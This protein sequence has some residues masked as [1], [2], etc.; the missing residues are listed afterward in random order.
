MKF[1]KTA[2][3]DCLYFFTVITW[4]LKM[5]HH[6]KFPRQIGDFGS[7]SWSREMIPLWVWKSHHFPSREKLYFSPV[8]FWQTVQNRK[9]KQTC[10]YLKVTWVTRLNSFQIAQQ[11]IISLLYVYLKVIFLK[12]TSASGSCHKLG[13]LILRVTFFCNFWATF[14]VISHI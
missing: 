7:M 13:T 3:L 1:G 2:Q 12:V 6:L 8:Y 4:G 10:R 5:R 9:E 14:D 11:T